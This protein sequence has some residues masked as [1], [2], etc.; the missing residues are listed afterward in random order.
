MIINIY[1]YAY[2]L[3]ITFNVYAYNYFENFAW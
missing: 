3:I 2:Y 1:S